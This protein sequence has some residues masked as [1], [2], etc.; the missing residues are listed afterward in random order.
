[1]TSLSDDCASN[2]HEFCNRCECICHGEEFTIEE[3]KALYRTVEHQYI[4]YE[5]V[6]AHE[7]TRKIMRILREH[8]LA[9][10]DSASS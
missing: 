4:S 6:A 3:L 1:M 2:I 9:R 10:R 7:V 8:E 5:D